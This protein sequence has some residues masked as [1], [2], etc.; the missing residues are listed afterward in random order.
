MSKANG[1]KNG[2]V[3]VIT[4]VLVVLLVLGGA[5]IIVRFAL[6]DQGLNY[7]VEYNDKKYFA[8]TESS[9]IWLSPIQENAFAVKSIT[10]KTIDYS[11]K[12]TANPDNNF[13]FIRD[14]KYFR[15]YS[16]TEESN[17]YTQIFEVQ[18]NT[19]S[20]TVIIPA[21]MTMQKAVEMRHGG[22]VEIPN[23][24]ELLDYFL[25]I[26]TVDKTNIIFPFSFIME[27]TLDSPSIIF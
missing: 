8:N 1:A 2:I 14:G 22:K 24:L 12:I 15:F 25:I 4:W 11:V 18:N 23:N 27:I 20:F 7:Y 3:K 19:G 5:G 13:D 16:T 6:K 26:V 10:G 9:E 17:D 21:G